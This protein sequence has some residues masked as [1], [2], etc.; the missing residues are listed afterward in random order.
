VLLDLV[1]DYAWLQAGEIRLVDTYK[2]SQGVFVEDALRYFLA[3]ELEAHTRNHRS[4]SARY[5]ILS[6][7]VDAY[8]MVHNTQG[9]EDVLDIRNGH[10]VMVPEAFD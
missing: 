9:S 3:W 4:A 1:R 2:E 7:V 6:R 8:A 10:L 5:D